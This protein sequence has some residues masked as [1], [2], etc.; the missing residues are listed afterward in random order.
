MYYFGTVA[1]CATIALFIYFTYDTYNAAVN[2]AYISVESNNGGDKCNTVSISITGT[3]YADYNGYWEGSPQFV[4]SYSPYEVVFSNFQVNS[5]AQYKDMIKSFEANLNKA[6]EVAATQNLALNLIYWMNYIDFYYVADPSLQNYTATGRGQLQYLD[7]M[8]DPNQV[9]DQSY[10]QAHVMSRSGFCT[11]TSYATFDQANVDLTTQ[12]NFTQLVQ[13]EICAEGIN[14]LCFGYYGPVDDGIFQLSMDMN[15]FSTAMAVNLGIVQISNLGQASATFLDIQVGNVTFLA[16][17]YFDVRFPNMDTIFCLH[18]VTAYPENV[19]G[20]VHD[21]EQLCFY[22]FGQTLALPVFNHYG[23]SD[24][25][26]IYCECG[27]NGNSEDC[28]VFDLMSGLVYFNTPYDPD[29]DV[30]AI[31]VIINTG[32]Y[33]LMEVVSRFKSYKDFNRAAYNISF[34]ASAPAYGLE[35]PT[36]Q[37]QAWRNS[38]FDFCTVN[39]QSCSILVYN[40]Y[41][42]LSQKVTDY[43]FQLTNGSC[44]NSLSTTQEAW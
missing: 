4:Y 16:G 11:V 20:T 15:T 29:P 7:M 9:F 24:E 12:L 39:G 10:I 43:K 27:V 14:P 37:S 8:G 25:D 22:E 32:L 26:P 6:G 23:T 36:V 18:N 28:N 42:Q 19:D 31:K 38:S 1:Y 17:K 44:V 34:A 35:S 40:T 2:K 21:V 13:D 33:Q 3:Y 30:N 41:D 5:D